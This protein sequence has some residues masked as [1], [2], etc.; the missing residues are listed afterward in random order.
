MFRSRVFGA[1]GSVGMMVCESVWWDTRWSGMYWFPV[2]ILGGRS[3]GVAS[4]STLGGRSVVCTGGGGGT[5]GL[6]RWTITL[7]DSG[8]FSLGAGW[9]CCSG[10][11]RKMSR[12]RVRFFKR[13]VCS[14]S[15]TSLMAHDRKWRAWTIRSSGVTVGCV[16]YEW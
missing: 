9:V 12:M 6:G 11:V 5:G 15:G 1:G 10:L 2:A 3:G 4:V 7:G 8:G 16:R 13:S 14:V